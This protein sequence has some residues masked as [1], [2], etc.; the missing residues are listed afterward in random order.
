[1]FQGLQDTNLARVQATQKYLLNCDH[2][3]IATRISRAVTDATLKSALYDELKR[4]VPLAWEESGAGNTNFRL[5]VICTRS[6][7]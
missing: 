2:V 1:M 5:A 3:F 7:V 6:E 4:H